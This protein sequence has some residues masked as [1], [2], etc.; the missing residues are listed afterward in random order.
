MT[1]WQEHYKAVR[2]RLNKPMQPKIVKVAAPKPPPEDYVM[3]APQPEPDTEEVRR[4]IRLKGCPLST[5]RQFLVLPILEEFNLTWEKLWA[6]DKR[7]LM[8]EPRRKVW[9]KLW[10]DGMSISQIGTFTR[11]DHSTVL[12]GLKFI[13][14]A[15][16]EDKACTTATL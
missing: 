1:N 7:A 10:E 14:K 8:H 3:P 4:K 9:L 11:R 15:Q 5:R 13:K 2:D 12:H 6:K 16:S